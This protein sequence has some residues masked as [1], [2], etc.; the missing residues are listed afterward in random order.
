[1]FINK[2]GKILKQERIK[3]NLTLEALSNMT[4]IS[5]STLSNI[6]NDKIENIGGVFL[7]RLS[8]AFNIDYNYFDN[9]CDC[10]KDTYRCADAK[11]IILLIGAQGMD[12]AEGL[13]ENILRK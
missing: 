6:E 1:M 8:K 4:N 10:L 7:Y 13:L 2:I 12:P 9:L 5:I 11:D 3:N